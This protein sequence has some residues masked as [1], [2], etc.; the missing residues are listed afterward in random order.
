MAFTPFKMTRW[1]AGFEEDSIG[2]RGK[3]KAFSSQGQIALNH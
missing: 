2:R 1:G 3:A